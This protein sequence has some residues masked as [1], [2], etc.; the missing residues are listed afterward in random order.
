MVGAVL[1]LGSCNKDDDGGDDP[2]DL[3]KVGCHITG[4]ATSDMDLMLDA[5]QVVEPSSDY[6]TKVER[7]GMWYGIHYLSVGSLSFSEVTDDGENA[8]GAI[9]VSEVTQDAE[10]GEAF[11]YDAGTLVTDG[12]ETAYSVKAAGL[13]YIMLDNST[14]KFW[15]MPIKNI[16]IQATGDKATEVSATADAATFEVKGVNIKSGFKVRLNTAWKFVLED[17]AWNESDK[18]GFADDHVR[19][20]ISYG[21]STSALT[22]EGNDITVENGGKLLDF[23][24]NWVTGEKGIAGLTIATSEGEDLPK[25]DW[26]VI[27][28]ETVGAGVSSENPGAIADPTWGWGNVLF[29]NNNTGVP[30]KSGD[31]YTYTWDSVIFEASTG[32]ANAWRVVDEERKKNVNYSH[33]DVDNSSANVID[34]DP[35]NGDRNMEFAEKGTYKIV[36]VIDSA[37]E[38]ATVMTITEI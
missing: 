24:F 37:N 27:K 10:A 5:K 30:V 17:V 12:N 26:S 16:E 21:G 32:G 29:S 34:V 4:S 31:V 15:V 23:A 9:N 13:Y 18:E 2:I 7:D 6:A 33:L 22:A 25:T 11:T 8:I 35:S 36:I 19:P 1:T 28:L 3:K 20:V 38:D 14:D